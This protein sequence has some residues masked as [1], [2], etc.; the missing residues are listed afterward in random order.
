MNRITLDLLVGNADKLKRII[1]NKDYEWNRYSIISEDVS[2]N[3]IW[4]MITLQYDNLD[5]LI[6]HLLIEIK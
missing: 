6:A 3:K 1:T 4:N 2:E 5:A